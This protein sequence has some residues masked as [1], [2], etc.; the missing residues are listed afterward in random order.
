M[1]FA[2]APTQQYSQPT[3]WHIDLS[4]PVALL[5]SLIRF[6]SVTPDDA[7]SFEFIA[8]R[9]VMLG[10]EVTQLEHNG[11]K[12]LVAHYFFSEH[13]PK[14][15]FCGH[16]DVV[17]AS[18]KGWCVPPF[19]GE[20]VGDLIIGRGAADMKGAIAAMLSA[21]AALISSNAPAI[22]SF[23]WLITCDEEGEAEFGSQEI[24]R[25]LSANRIELDACLVGEPTSENDIGDTIKNGRRGALSGRIKINGK[26]GHVAYP[27]HTINAASL[28]A[29]TITQLDAI[30]WAHDLQGSYTALQVTDM[31]IA[32]PV[33]NIV[34]AR[35]EVAFNVRY[36]HGYNSRLIKKLIN[37]AIE[38]VT[39]DYA[40]EW[41]RPC[42][43]YYTGQGKGRFELLGLAERV[44]AEETGHFPKLSTAGGTSDGRFFASDSTQVIELGLKNETIHQVNE[45]VSVNDVIKLTSLYTVLLKQ[46]FSV[47]Q[48]Y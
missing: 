32:E 38:K 30:E 31:T 24:A 12:N 18:N 33:D 11:V 6:P 1:S 7:G 40:V 41:Q 36:G 9:L 48:D 44:I 16:L 4:N 43:P 2:I 27:E 28:A 26:A 25:Y 29:K 8:S 3:H 17:P 15:G 5:Q 21:S 10:F 22:G 19:S 14:I 23:Y 37:S 34:P 20:R 45:A 42:E 46:A 35:A 13:G 39:Q 47:N